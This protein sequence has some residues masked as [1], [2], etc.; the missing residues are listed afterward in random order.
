[1]AETIREYRQLARD[2]L[3]AQLNKE[4]GWSYVTGGSGIV[5]HLVDSDGGHRNETATNFVRDVISPLQDETQSAIVRYQQ[6][7]VLEHA[8]RG[9]VELRLANDLLGT[10]MTV[11]EE[12]NG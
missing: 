7:Q 3:D 11:E 4:W 8:L 2:L 5:F 12:T 1:M 6:R 9:E 10:V